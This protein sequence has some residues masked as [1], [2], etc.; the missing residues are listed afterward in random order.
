M[1]LMDDTATTNEHS[2]SEPLEAAR[3][4][5]T[6]TPL[7]SRSGAGQLVAGLLAGIEHLIANRPRAVPQIEEAYREPWATTD[8]LTVDGLD[9]PMDRPE[10]PDRSG[11]RL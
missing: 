5:P 7:P 2:G 6:S 10:P 3:A 9:E 11:A 1:L 4:A 8:G